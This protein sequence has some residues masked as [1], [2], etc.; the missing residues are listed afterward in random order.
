MLGAGLIYELDHRSQSSGL[1][2]ADRPD[3]QKKSLGFSGKRFENRRQIQF[4]QR[5]YVFWN[6]T[7]SDGE[8]ALAIVDIAAETDVGH[9]VREIG[10]AIGL[11]HLYI[12]GGQKLIGKT[13][14][15]RCRENRFFKQRD[16]G[17]RN[18][19]YRRAPLRQMQI[20]GVFFDEE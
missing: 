3:N 6:E 5:F 19:D 13:L 17:S 11:E 18:T 10:I 2:L 14:H 8:D 4:G 20:R 7:Q 9:L 1:A 12:G 16:Q 15:V